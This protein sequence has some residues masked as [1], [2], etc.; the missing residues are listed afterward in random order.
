MQRKKITDIYL[1]LSVYDTETIRLGIVKYFGMYPVNDPELYDAATKLFA[2]FRII[3]AV[4]QDYIVSGTIFGS[5]GKSKKST[6]RNGRS[7]VAL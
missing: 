4:P 1:A 2:F 5:L 7:D 3:F 6:R